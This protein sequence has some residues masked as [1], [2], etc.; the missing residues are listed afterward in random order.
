MDSCGGITQAF[1]LRLS[2]YMCFGMPSHLPSCQ[3]FSQGPLCTEV[4]MSSCPL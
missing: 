3:P 2:S 4:L 1:V